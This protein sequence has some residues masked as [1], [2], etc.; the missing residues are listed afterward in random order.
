VAKL[1][2]QLAVELAL[3]WEE[4][5]SIR[6][7]ARV[8]DLGKVAI[9]AGIPTKPNRLSADE[10]ALMEDHPATGA[11]IVARFPEF[12]AGADYVRFHHERCDDKGYPKGLRGKEIPLGAAIITV[13]DAYDAMTSDQPYRKA[14]DV[15]MTLAEFRHGAG[16]QWDEQ[17]VAALLRVVTRDAVKPAVKALRFAAKPERRSGRPA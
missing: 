7:A 8:H 17:V 5:E 6:A 15:D 4:V 13:A 12:A 16:V 2:G 11:E 10:W 3:S 1:G 9:D 14:L